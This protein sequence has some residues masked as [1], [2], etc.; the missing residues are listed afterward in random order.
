MDKHDKETKFN[1]KKAITLGV[2]GVVAGI[3]VTGI[4]L[5]EEQELINLAHPT[6]EVYAAT[7]DYSIQ[8]SDYYVLGGKEYKVSDN[9]QA[10]ETLDGKR[11]SA[12]ANVGIMRAISDGKDTI[13][14][15]Y[16]GKDNKGTEYTTKA[17]VVYGKDYSKTLT[18]LDDAITLYENGLI[19]VK[20][21]QDT[22]D[23]NIAK[24]KD[25]QSDDFGNLSK[26][27]D[28]VKTLMVVL[29]DKE[30]ALSET[31]ATDIAAMRK[32]ESEYADALAHVITA[33]KK[34]MVYL[35]VG[36]DDAVFTD[37]QDALDQN[38]ALVNEQDTVYDRLEELLGN[39]DN[40]EE[41]EVIDVD[42]DGKETVIDDVDEYIEDNQP[43]EEAPDVEDVVDDKDLL[44]EPKEPV[45]E[46][47]VT[48]ETPI[49][50]E[51][52]DN[53]DK[54]DTNKE[55]TTKPDT[56]PVTDDKT[57]ETEEKES[58]AKESAKESAGE[59]NSNQSTSSE[60][61]ASSQS[62]VSKAS[63][64]SSSSKVSSSSSSS[65]ASNNSSS[66]T[67]SN[68]D[69]KSANSSDLKSVIDREVS[70]LDESPVGE[71]AVIDAPVITND[72]Q[73][74]ENTFDEMP[75][76][77]A[78]VRTREVTEE[79]EQETSP[80]SSV[81]EMPEDPEV[82]AR[83]N[84]EGKPTQEEGASAEGSQAEATQEEGANPESGQAEAT[85]A[86][87]EGN[88]TLPETGTDLNTFYALLVFVGAGFAA[89]LA[90]IK[91]GGA[92]RFK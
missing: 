21:N 18:A 17:N 12:I 28:E 47:T 41:T 19:A 69:N 61:K 24:A 22:Y 50:S 52:P 77:G 82:A 37:A 23:E 83:A 80:N 38:L 20:G 40:P 57:K 32:S 45:I 1:R 92:K 72:N 26:V 88:E 66:S 4:L 11:V 44:E 68:S 3:S 63:S 60:S 81:V 43:T 36:L 9:V 35:Q 10:F 71:S 85:K 87:A 73:S 15:F 64:S 31:D 59:S 58:E 34:G 67:T 75:E 53:T 86:S 16:I 7:S 27:N 29:S 42:E 70:N 84:L 90:K 33:L 39:T 25:G 5:S 49:E 46:D 91:M 78:D 79:H 14:T 54:E 76:Y 89:I 8:A 65:K 62:S 30:K 2:A 74:S 56:T 51:T 13:T 6:E 55:E 48:P